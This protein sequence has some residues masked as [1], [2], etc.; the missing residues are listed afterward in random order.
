MEKVITPEF[1]VSFPH[2]FKAHAFQDQEPKFRLTMLFDKAADLSA[3]KQLASNA[4]VEKWGK[5]IPADLRSPFRDGSE[6]EDL[7]GYEGMVF[8]NA[9]SKQKPGVVDENVQDI[10]DETEFYA[11][12]YARA[13]VTA[14][15]YDAMGNRGVSFGLQNVQKLRDG[16]P[17]SGR[18]KASDDFDAVVKPGAPVDNEPKQAGASVFA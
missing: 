17:F 1:R 3:M 4:A 5:K 15:A 12:C 10:M 8:I 11:G 6:K 2:V 7:E 9:T 16:E 18:T 14:Y 13:T